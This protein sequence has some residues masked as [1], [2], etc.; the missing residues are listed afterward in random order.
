VDPGGTGGTSQTIT[1]VVPGVTD[2][3]PE[4]A[5]AIAAAILA[6]WGAAFAWRAIRESL[7]GQDD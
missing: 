5:I 7:N 1:L 4:T 6:A 2:L 3:D